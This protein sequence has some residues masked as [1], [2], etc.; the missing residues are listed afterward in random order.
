MQ[1]FN[2]GLHA[3]VEPIGVVFKY[4]SAPY[5]FIYKHFKIHLAVCSGFNDGLQT[6]GN[7]FTD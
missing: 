2:L 5:V 6:L 7:V 1:F 4:E 3:C